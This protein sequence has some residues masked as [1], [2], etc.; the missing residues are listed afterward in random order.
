MALDK[1]GASA[2]N[3]LY[4]GD[5]LVDAK[6]AQNLGVSFAAVLSGV[7]P[8]EAFEPYPTVQVLASIKD[9][10]G[11][12]AQANLKPIQTTTMKYYTEPH[13]PQFH[14]SPESGWLNDPNGMV[15]YDGEYHLFYQFTPGSPEIPGPKHWGHAV[16]RDMVHWEHLPAALSPD[17]LGEIWSGSAVV[18][19]KNTSGLQSGEEAVLV[20][21]FTQ[22]DEGY[23]QQ[24]LAYSNDRGRTWTKYNQN[25]V[26]PGANLQDFR[27]PKVFWHDESKHWVLVLAAG[28]RVMFYN[29]QNLIDWTFTSQFG[30]LE[31][32]HGGVWE[33]PDLFPLQVDG[34]PELEMWVLLVSVGSGAPAGSSGTQYFIGNFDGQTFGNHSPASTIKWLDYGSDNYAGVTFS[35]I[36]ERRILMGWM[37]NWI[38]AYK[39]PTQVWRGAMTLPRKLRLSSDP[40]GDIQLRSIPITELENLRA[41]HIQFCDISVSPTERTS[42][43]QAIKAARL[44]IQAEIALEDASQFGIC[45]KSGKDDVLLVGYDAQAGKLFIDRRHSGNVG[46]D[47]SFGRHIHAAPLS[48]DSNR[49]KYHIFIDVSS[50]EVFAEN[51]RVVLTDLYFANSEIC[52]VEIYALEGCVQ[53][54]DVEVWTMSSIWD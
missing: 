40:K 6:T 31:G 52:E 28:D 49:L 7:T 46:F 19:W 9:L 22:F 10:P 23:Q 8:G 36:P 33:C 20:A 35:D 26:I 51:G 13:R 30:E 11:W 38:Y 2:G 12:I 48:L 14:F 50:I 24:S 47:H 45:L 41:E 29:S 15:Y 21:V 5:S 1:L 4:V 3:T 25:P 18:D 43:I 42:I 54:V 16:S 27:D 39:V 44:E 37:S 17:D 34:D 53:V 32:A